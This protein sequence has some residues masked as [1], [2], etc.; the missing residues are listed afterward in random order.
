MQ[1]RR[2]ITFG[3]I[4][5][6]ALSL[7]MC[8]CLVWRWPYWRSRGPATFS[9]IWYVERDG[10]RLAVYDGFRLWVVFS[11]TLPC[12]KCHH[13]HRRQQDCEGGWRRVHFGPP[14]SL[15]QWQFGP[16]E[17]RKTQAGRTTEWKYYC[18][19]WV[20]IPLLAVYPIVFLVSALGRRRPDHCLHCDYDLTGNESGV[21]P[22]CGTAIVEVRAAIKAGRSERTP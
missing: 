13:P 15:H 12:E 2:F 6:M 8:I 7:G 3:S 14:Q 19:D 4:L 11:Q 20:P 1:L 22:E 17:G 18:S 10:R 21:C 5:A 16:F 9:E